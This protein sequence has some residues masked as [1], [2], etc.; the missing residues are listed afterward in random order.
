M[1]L[2]A[3]ELMDYLDRDTQ[4]EEEVRQRKVDRWQLT[5]PI[6]RCLRFLG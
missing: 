1:E 2:V 4:N 3:V 5:W 6:V